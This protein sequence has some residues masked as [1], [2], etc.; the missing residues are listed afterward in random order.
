MDIT[1][2]AYK[3][4][5]SLFRPATSSTEP[6]TTIVAW[7]LA[8][9]FK[10]NS[11]SSGKP[12]NNPSSHALWIPCAFQY[13]WRSPWVDVRA[14]KSIRKAPRPRNDKGRLRHTILY[15]LTEAPEV[16]AWVC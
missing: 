5:H 1:V 11:K 10:L 8:I 7:L 3:T 9:H 16:E 6:P 13:P 12:F 15:G 14:S 2:T 4:L